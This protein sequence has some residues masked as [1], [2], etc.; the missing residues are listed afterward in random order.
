MLRLLVRSATGAELTQY[1]TFHCGPKRPGDVDGPEEMHIVLVDN[2][3]TR[4]LVEGQ[5]E[6]LRCI[7]CGACMNHCVVFRQIGGHAYGG[8][9]PGP[10]GAV[11]TPTFMG[12]E[13]SRELV[14]ACTMNGRC[15]EVCPVEIPL[16]ALLRGWRDRSWREGLEPGTVRYGIGLWAFVARR[17]AL[18]RLAS[19]IGV[20]VMRLFRRRG[21]INSLPLAGGWTG[22]RD[23]PAPPGKTFMELHRARRPERHREKVS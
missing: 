12:L 16:P 11:L 17:P 3:R 1:T 8:T 6:M 5:R 23:L 13:K 19:R 2:G 14:H 7:R 22:H 4:M 9:Y 21:W 18:Y 10:M 15:Q 20:R